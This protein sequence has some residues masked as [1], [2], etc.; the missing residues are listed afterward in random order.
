MGGGALGLWRHRWGPGPLRPVVLPWNEIKG[1]S[2]GKDSKD[3]G[4]A[5]GR[6]TMLSMVSLALALDFILRQPITNGLLMS[7]W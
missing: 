3:G 7:G 2:K 4:A 1:Q 6:P 5:F